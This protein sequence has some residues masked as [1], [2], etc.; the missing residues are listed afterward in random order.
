MCR[1]KGSISRRSRLGMHFGSTLSVTSDVFMCRCLDSSS[2]HSRLGM[3]FAS[4]LVVTSDF[5]HVQVQG[6]QQQAQP[7]GHA[8]IRSTAHGLANIVRRHGWAGLFRGL[9]INYMKVAPTTAIG[10]AVY[11]GMKGYLDLPRHM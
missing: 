3:H 2:R 9:S 11:D 5:W 4:T 6:L 10:F 1:G 8:A 7:P